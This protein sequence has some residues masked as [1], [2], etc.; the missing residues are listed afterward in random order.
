MLDTIEKH[1]IAINIAWVILTGLLT[2]V[3]KKPSDAFAQKWPRIA[4]IRRIPSDAGLN[5]PNLMKNLFILV[6]GRPPLTFGAKAP[7]QAKPS[8]VVE[9]PVQGKTE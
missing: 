1:W 9:Q 2:V 6:A 4:A 8:E 5:V 3:F 7:E